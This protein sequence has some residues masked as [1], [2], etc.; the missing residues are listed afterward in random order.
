M[1]IDALEMSDLPVIM[2]AIL[3]V[4]SIF[5]LVNILV[6]ISYTVLDPRIKLEEE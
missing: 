6:D 3:F 5:V 2:G 4:A 1:T